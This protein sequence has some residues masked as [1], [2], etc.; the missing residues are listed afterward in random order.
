MLSGCPQLKILQMVELSRY[1]HEL[2][3]LVFTIL[4]VGQS[5]CLYRVSDFRQTWE[6]EPEASAPLQLQDI[7]MSGCISLS[8][9]HI[10]WMVLQLFPGLNTLRLNSTRVTLATL[11]TL[12]TNSGL[13]NIELAPERSKF[14]GKREWL[15]LKTKYP[16][17]RFAGNLQR[18]KSYQQQL[19]LCVF[20]H[21]ETTD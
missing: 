17:V 13:R 14:I 12:C 3:D 18:R 8:S 9:Q 6:S 20:G 21:Q 16:K 11:S 2:F 7:D 4:T 5:I 10:E 15:Q 1:L 19:S